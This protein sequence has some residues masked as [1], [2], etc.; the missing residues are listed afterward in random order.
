MKLPK[1]RLR[2][3]RV[4]VVGLYR[5]GKTVFLTSLINHLQ[6]HNPRQFRLGRGDVKLIFAG[7]REPS[8]FAP[9]PYLQYRNELVNARQ[10]PTK[11]RGI[12]EYTFGYYRSDWHVTRGEMTLVDFPGE[13]LADLMMAKAS[14]DQWS[15]LLI[16]IFRNHDEY[17]ALAEPYLGAFDAGVPAES[18][19]IEGYRQL[20]LRLFLGFRPIVSPSAFLLSPQGHW[21]GDVPEAQYLDRC[22]SGLDAARQFAPMPAAARQQQPDLRKAFAQRYDEYRR[23]IALPLARWM[24]G[25]D[26]LTVLL[27]VTTL[28]AAGEGMY[29]GNR[30]LLSHLIQQLSPG[31]GYFGLSA[32]VLSTVLSPVHGPLSALLDL[33][34]HEIDRVAFVAT[35]ADKVHESDRPRLADLVREMT[36]GLIAAHQARAVSL[37]VGYFACAAVKSTRSVS[38]G[39]LQAFV[40]A[41][42]E[43][44]LF[45]PSRV[46]E[47]W[48]PTWQHGQFLFPNVEPWIPPRRDAAPDHIELDR[49]ADFLMG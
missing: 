33:N 26:A 16:T 30:E 21:L 45:A 48:P 32:D 13:R 24:R 27:D 44:S 20:L 1:F 9:F 5:S 18:A 14:Y 10:W 28:L 29:Q 40:G 41:G 17:R 35:K 2:R 31:K 6:N 22:F 37:E 39:K 34:W 23:E 49:V 25:C 8:R 38:E 36:E 43:P 15:D 19:V 47:Q 4:G 12:S 42:A 7:Q 11:T 46:P 3:Q